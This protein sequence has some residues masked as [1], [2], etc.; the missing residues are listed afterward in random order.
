LTNFQLAS[1]AR[2][3]KLGLPAEQARVSS[4]TLLL[5]VTAMLAYLATS[6][7]ARALRAVLGVRARNVAR[8]LMMFPLGFTVL[9]AI[10]GMLDGYVASALGMGGLGLVA[11]AGSAFAWWEFRNEQ[12]PSDEAEGPGLTR[13]KHP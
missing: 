13:S 2:Q 5:T 4:V 11:T 10:A 7:P 8:I 3:R 12:P 6:L 1:A 9:G